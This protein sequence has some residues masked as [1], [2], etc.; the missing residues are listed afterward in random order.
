MFRYISYKTFYN[1]LKHKY[2][3]HHQNHIR[4]FEGFLDPLPQSEEKKKNN[5]KFKTGSMNL[6]VIL[7]FSR[8]EEGDP[9]IFQTVVC[10][11][12]LVERFVGLNVVKCFVDYIFKTSTN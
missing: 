3:H 8:T 9:R 1:V 7:L 2:A 11:F 10:G 12:N 5:E 4:Q 6:S